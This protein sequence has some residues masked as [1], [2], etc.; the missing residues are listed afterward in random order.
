MARTPLMNRLLALARDVRLARRFDVDVKEVRARRAILRESALTR[1][2][3]L[4][5][6]A[7]GA[8]TLA[9]PR[10]VFAAA[11]PK[12]RIAIV[13]GGMAGLSAALE[14]Q[15]RGLPSTIYEM[16][17]RV[18]GRVF[19]RADGYWGGQVSEWGGELIDTGHKRMRKLAK[20]FRLDLVNLLD[21]E[22]KKS[23]DV[24]HFGGGY[25]SEDEAVADFLAMEDLVDADLDG[26]GYP[27]TFD[28]FTTAGLA[29]DALSV[30]D[31][32]EAR[33]PG[34]HASNFGKLLDVAYNGE[35]SA[36]TTDQSALNLL[37]LLGYQPKNNDFAVFGES[38][39]KFHID[40]GNEQLPKRIAKRIGL[41]KIEL[42]HALTAIVARAD[43]T[44][45]L[46]FD[47]PGGPKSVIADAVILTL[48]FAVLRN[49]DLA[50]AGFEPLKLQAIQSLGRGIGGK[51][52]MQFTERYW[53]G[54]GAWAAHGCNGN[55]YSDLGYQ[56][57]WE[58]TR[59]Q[60]GKAGI[61]NVFTGGNVALGLTTTAP[62]AD[63]FTPSVV[64]DVAGKLPL[65]DTVFPGIAS[66]HNGLA[67]SSL[68]HL[69]ANFGLTYSYYRVGQYTTFGGIEG[70]TQGRI[71]FA[72]E[73]T[74]RDFQGF[75]EG[76]A[77][78][79]ER[80]GKEVAKKLDK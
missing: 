33:V 22:P 37:Y 39:E 66:R 44:V 67:T 79:G 69:A 45:E 14:L 50:N 15:D 62:F 63:A 10:S 31:W 24:H 41:E 20:R 12:P 35:Y 60:K 17:A 56:S 65:L 34:G 28:D 40:G 75:M 54:P 73:H 55:T 30:H 80:A 18:G 29:L 9:V 61:L 7:A 78:E 46:A 51:L 77:R 59:G 16:S 1:R 49:L 8:L 64:T 53:T 57:T 23:E 52:Q 58:V 6:V 72:G 70:K 4:R 21:A 76:A 32:I 68:P 26:A 5:S 27:T 25:Y 47:T 71:W 43:N 38:D 11:K 48:P 36:E 3:A 42:E 74:S 19:S 13:G 2:E